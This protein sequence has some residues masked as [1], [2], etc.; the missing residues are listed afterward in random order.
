VPDTQL[1][2][3]KE[4]TLLPTASESAGPWGVLK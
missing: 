2:R 1:D 3:V 4:K